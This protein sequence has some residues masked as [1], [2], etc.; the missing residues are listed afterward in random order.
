MRIRA[1]LRIPQ[2]GHFH[3]EPW[4]LMDLGLSNFQSN[5][6]R[7]P[8]RNLNID[9]MNDWKAGKYGRNFISMEVS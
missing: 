2:N 3:G 7:N 4:D 1:R 6:C 9:I 8:C 5:P